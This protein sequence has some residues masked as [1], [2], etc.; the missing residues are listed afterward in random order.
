MPPGTIS[1]LSSSVRRTRRSPGCGSDRGGR[2]VGQTAYDRRLE[3]RTL[4]FHPLQAGCQDR[5]T[6][7]QRHGRQSRGGIPEGA[8]A[9]GDPARQSL[10]VRVDRIPAG[11]QR[12]KGDETAAQPRSREAPAPIRREP[13]PRAGRFRGKSCRPWTPSAATRWPAP[14]RHEAEHIAK[15][16]SSCAPNGPAT[17]SGLAPTAE[18][19]TRRRNPMT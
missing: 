3:G 14:G 17:P 11:L 1:H 19:D 2:D 13:G 5:E 6:R 4:T 10:L 7:S 12:P 8:A 18:S 9:P 16:T 15:E